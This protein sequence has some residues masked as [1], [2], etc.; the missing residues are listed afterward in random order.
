MK[1]KEDRSK[2]SSYTLFLGCTVPVRALNYE[3]ASRKVAGAL[4][5]TLHDIPEFTCCG[6]PV[7][8]ISHHAYLLMAARNLALAEAKGHPICTLCSSCCGSLAEANRE[9]LE[10]PSLRKR[11]NEELYRWVGF[12]YEGE[13]KVSHLTRILHREV[14]TKKI[15][16]EVR[17]D[18]SSLR[19]AA[20]YGC[21]FTK[22]SDL[23]RRA[24]DPENP[25]SLDEL[26][27]ATGAQ[28]LA[29]EEKLSCCGG[30]VLAIDEQV[31]L[32]M[33]QRK[34]D[35]IHA[36]KA[37][38]I[39]LICPFCSVMYESNQKKIEKAFEKDYK[40]PV[41]YYPQLLGLALGIDPDELGLKM[42][43]IRTSD[44]LKKI[45]RPA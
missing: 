37:D 10:D 29:Y 34:L 24:D 41:L 43:R 17:A 2:E 44:L 6:Y 20:H 7:K 27:E 28:S 30:G 18:L 42:N 16:K 38:A 25:K 21:H 32:G 11:I 26:I 5:L 35:H 13:V 12:R 3:L 9:L 1:K 36:Q 33:A 14:G 15:E 31:A 23:Y 4:G 40:L 39:V 8:S 45:R 22:P 19:V